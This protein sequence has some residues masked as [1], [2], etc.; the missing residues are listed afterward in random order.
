MQSLNVH[1]RLAYC[2]E[3]ERSPW[4]EARLV[5]PT[6][7]LVK[8]V[9]DIDGELEGLHSTWKVLRQ[10]WEG[11]WTE[12]E[13]ARQSSTAEAEEELQLALTYLAEEAV[14]PLAWL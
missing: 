13:Q 4:L 2:V 1:K 12:E 10:Q 5:V 6:L 3:A 9:A 14:G 7:A 8:P 11:L